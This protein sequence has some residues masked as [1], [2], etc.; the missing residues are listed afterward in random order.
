MRLLL[1]AALAAAV[2]SLAHINKTPCL[3]G[4]DGVT[5]VCP[6]APVVRA[7][8]AQA[9]LTDGSEA[10]AVKDEAQTESVVLKI[11][12]VLL[13]IL[14]PLLTA[15]V[16][17]AV[18]WL[19]SQE[20]T[21]KLAYVGSIVG[22]LTL[23]ALAHFKTDLQ[24]ALQEALKDG[25]LDASERASLKAKLIEMLKRD[26]PRDVLAVAQKAF[27]AGFELWLAGQAERAID[28]AA[29]AVSPQ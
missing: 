11:L 16:A 15:L 12:G 21:N 10:G 27:G 24:P 6:E 18:A 4:D 28:A 25:V 17:K 1:L 29:S 13:G 23:S 3:L 22:D 26:L 20:K 2:P 8:P 19:H 9:V 7:T 5:V 14:T